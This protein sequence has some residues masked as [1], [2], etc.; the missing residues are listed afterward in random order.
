MRQG[1]QHRLLLNG[2]EIQLHP[3]RFLMLPEKNLADL[4]IKLDPAP[5]QRAAITMHRRDHREEQ[6]VDCEFGQG[7]RTPQTT[8][9]VLR[10]RF[11]ILTD[12]WI[13]LLLALDLIGDVP[14]VHEP[15]DLF[16]VEWPHV[17]HVD[18]A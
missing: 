17:E 11:R 4:S 8:E 9:Q 6:W 3:M 15:V 1:L 12:A 7:G 14:I 5:R 10:A 2:C 18:A 13:V 16:A